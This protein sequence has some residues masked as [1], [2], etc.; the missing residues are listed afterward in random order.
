[1]SVRIEEVVLE[2]VEEEGAEGA[3]AGLADDEGEGEKL[4]DALEVPKDEE[5][6]GIEAN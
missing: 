1:M 2:V 4:G 3:E 5:E 6:D